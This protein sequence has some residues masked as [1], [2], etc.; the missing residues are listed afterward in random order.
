MRQVGLAYLSA[1][2]L[3]AAGLYFRER[4]RFYLSYLPAVGVVVL[5]L[6][7]FAAGFVYHLFKPQVLMVVVGMVT[8]LGVWLGRQFRNSA[9][10]LLA[11]IGVYLTPL[12]MPSA[13]GQMTELLIYY[14]AAGFFFCYCSFLEGNR[15]A[16]LI[17]MYMGMLGFDSIWRLSNKEDW[18]FAITYQLVQFCLFSV[19]TA[20]FSIRLRKPLEDSSLIAHLLGLFIFYHIAFGLLNQYL[21]EFAHY[22]AIC[23]GFFV[24]LIFMF[25]KRFFPNSGDLNQG[26]TVV[27]WYC[28]WILVHAV[29]FG[30]IPDRWFAWSVLTIP[31]ILIFAERLFKE[32]EGALLP[33]RICCGGIYFYGYAILLL[34]VIGEDADRSPLIMPSLTLAAHAILLFGIYLNFSRVSLSPVNSVLA[35]YGAHLAAIVGITDIMPDEIYSS[36]VWA[37]YALFVLVTAVQLKDKA[38]GR[39]AL[40]I[41]L[42]AGVTIL[43]FGLAGS[44]S[45]VKILLLLAFSVVMYLGGWFYQNLLGDEDGSKS[46]K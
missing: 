7:T 42:L 18:L 13:N 20:L 38:L 24:L 12:L 31:V 39:S 35:L 5:Y 16:Y 22:V 17:P 34:T 9:Y 30:V 15:L 23:S 29:F 45:V 10:V 1:G 36:L 4:A 3:I 40:L 44:S 43:L 46:N 2:G 28:S 37:V 25:A 6:T 19:N 32:S 14:L 33:I 11:A 41:F 8:L 21:P 26:S 27:S